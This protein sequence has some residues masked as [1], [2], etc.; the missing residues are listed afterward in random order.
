M[1]DL[2][3]ASFG[4]SSYLACHRTMALSSE[5]WDASPVWLLCTLWDLNSGPYTC[6][7]GDI[8]MDTSLQS[9]KDYFLSL[10]TT[11]EECGLGIGDMAQSI[12]A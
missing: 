9:S 1:L 12:Q 7:P 3:R 5:W 11:F 6:V 2:E 10:K 4:Q 8:F